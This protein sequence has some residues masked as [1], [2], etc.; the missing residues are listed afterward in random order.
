L[1]VEELD[2][3]VIGLEGAQRRAPIAQAKQVA[4]HFVLA[5]LIR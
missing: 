2:A 5:Q 1:A 4:A 3:A